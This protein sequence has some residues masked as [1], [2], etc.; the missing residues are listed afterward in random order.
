MAHLTPLY[1]RHWP[2]LTVHP[3]MCCLHVTYDV[4]QGK[5]YC[6]TKAEGFRKHCACVILQNVKTEILLRLDLCFDHETQFLVIY[7]DQWEYVTRNVIQTAFKEAKVSFT[8]IP[9]FLHGFV[10]KIVRWA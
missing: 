2:R 8:D 10:V 5:G 4:I 6:F 1:L 7:Y 9:I 3:T